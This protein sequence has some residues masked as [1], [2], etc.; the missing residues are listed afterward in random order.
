[1]KTLF[2]YCR[3]EWA[4]FL[5]RTLVFNPKKRISIEEALA[6]PMFAKQRN[7]KL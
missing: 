1:M 6:H 3:P 5:E 4:D 2:N 7:E